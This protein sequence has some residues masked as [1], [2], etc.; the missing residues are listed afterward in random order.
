MEDNDTTVV[1][2]P[3]AFMDRYICSDEKLNLITKH[4][5]NIKKESPHLYEGPE[6]SIWILF[7]NIISKDL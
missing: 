3:P 5:E 7:G 4:L 1:P 2:C 6:F